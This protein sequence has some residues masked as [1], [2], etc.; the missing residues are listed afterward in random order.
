MKEL[1]KI[2]D[3]KS[4]EQK[5]IGELTPEK[6]LLRY[7]TA[8][9]HL[10]GLG[11]VCTAAIAGI[12]Y[13]FIELITDVVN[14]AALRNSR[15]VAIASLQI[16]GIHILKWFVTY[17]Q[18]FLISSATTK[19]AVRLRNELFSHLQNLSL[20]FFERTKT[21]HLLSRMT[22]DISLVQ[23]SSHSI[24]QVVSAPLIILVLTGKVF[25]MNWKLALISLIL[26]PL[27]YY[28]VIKI[29]RGM[30]SLTEVL[31]VK[32]ADIAAIVQETLSAI[33]IVKSFSMEDYEKSRFKD[34]NRRTYGAAML[35]VRRSAAMAPTLELIG[36]SGI[37]FVLWYGGS[38]VGS[39][40]FPQFTVGALFGFLVALEQ[41]SR[42]AKDVGRI[43]ITYHQ[44]MAGAQRIFDILDE[45]PEVQ[46]KPDAI[47]MPPIKGLVEFKDVC[48]SYQTGET[49]LKNISFTIEPGQHVALV[50]PSGAGKSTVASL[51][52]RFYDVTSGAVLIDGIDVRDVK[53]SSLRKQIGIVPQETVLFSSSVKEN[54]AYGRIGA[55]DSEIIEAAKAANAHDFIERLPQG[56]NTLVGERG[57]KLSGGERQRLA[58]ARALLK[59]PK[60]LILD[61]ATSSLDVASEAIVQEALD[62]LMSNRTTLIIAHRLSTIVNADKIIVMDKGRIVEMGTH[63][64][65][66]KQNGLYA[67][68][69]SVQ[70]RN[71]AQVNTAA[72]GR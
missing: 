26:L 20:G 68:L 15:L 14:A 57:V 32:L 3:G 8:H 17:G 45:I 11:L 34:E 52:L 55:T 35:A 10:F 22:N 64:E 2:K 1:D 18:V 30:R 62:R 63:D 53:A 58:I 60:L 19:I 67:K 48:F 23:N 59:N 29:S 27:M 28:V 61:E 69:Y 51:I 38:M 7:Y 37:A 6:R 13:W 42:A 12:Q 39:P 24:I 25:M 21:G 49:V 9:W 43:S 50:G 72:K 33:A 44:T 54:I 70:S 5:D 4:E 71:N 46:D 16:V 65:L 56:Y 36:V 31:Q 41:I 47:D 40:E 66:I